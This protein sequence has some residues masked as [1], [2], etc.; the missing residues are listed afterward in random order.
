MTRPIKRPP[1][2]RVL[3]SVC[4]EKVLKDNIV[5][6]PFDDGKEICF[7]CVERPKRRPIWYDEYIPAAP[8]RN[9]FRIQPWQQ[10]IDYDNE[11]RPE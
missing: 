7:R 4:K 5:A 1:A 2:K 9:P 10:I 8:R 3:C 11:I 6:N